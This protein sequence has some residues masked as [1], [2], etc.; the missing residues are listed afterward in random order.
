[1]VV[2]LLVAR[3]LLVTGYASALVYRLLSLRD[4][5]TAKPR[6]TGREVVGTDRRAGPLSDPSTAFALEQGVTREN[7]V[8]VMSRSG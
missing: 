2:A 1:L 7:G 5:A 6:Q 3:L 8:D 4:R